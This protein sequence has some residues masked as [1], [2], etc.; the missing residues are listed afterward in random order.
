M[1]GVQE[2]QSVIPLPFR[3]WAAVPS[4]PAAPHPSCTPSTPFACTLEA[5]RKECPPSLSIHEKA[6]PP[7]L[8]P[9]GLRTTCHVC[10][11]PHPLLRCG[12]RD[13]RD[14]AHPPFCSP[15]R[16]SYAT[17]IPQVTTCLP[18]SH[19]WWSPPPGPHLFPLHLSAPPHPHALLCACW[20]HRRDGGVHKGR[21]MQRVPRAR[22]A[23][24]RGGPCTRG[25]ASVEDHMQGDRAQGEGAWN[26]GQCNLGSKWWKHEGCCKQ[27]EA[28]PR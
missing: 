3:S 26:D 10:A 19:S 6:P 18:P 4:A 21:T 20:K 15:L 28:Q 24:G 5:G 7:R 11:L 9:P 1:P 25:H 22:R 13:R 17:P 16:L 27:G 12:G 2:G 23:C 14:N 8:L